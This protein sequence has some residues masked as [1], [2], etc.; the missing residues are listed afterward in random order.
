MHK[1]STIGVANE[2]DFNFDLGF[3][4]T[5]RASF[6]CFLDRSLQGDGPRS[7]TFL[8][9]PTLINNGKCSGLA[10]LNIF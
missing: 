4:L 5:S 3:D 10:L 6:D 7:Y 2:L 9:L 8:V 1:L